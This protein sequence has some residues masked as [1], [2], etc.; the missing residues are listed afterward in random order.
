MCAGLAG[1]HFGLGAMS[2][3][4]AVCFKGEDTA[5]QVLTSWRPCR[6]SI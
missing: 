5:D 4:L 2:D 6:K 3:L 1:C